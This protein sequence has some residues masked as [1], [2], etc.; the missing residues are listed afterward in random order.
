MPPTGSPG[1]RGTV[2]ELRAKLFL[3]LTPNAAGTERNTRPFVS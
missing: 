1:L 3:T 2:S